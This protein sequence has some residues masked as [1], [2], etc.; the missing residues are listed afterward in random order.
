MME[1]VSGHTIN[2]EK[3]KFP[4]SCPIWDCAIEAYLQRK[5]DKALM[6]ELSPKYWRIQ[7]E[8]R[9]ERAAKCV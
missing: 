3:V 6:D 4:H 2:G 5:A 1:L 7:A 8:L 9:G